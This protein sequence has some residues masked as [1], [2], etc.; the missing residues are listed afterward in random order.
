MQ[1][2]P[3]L[4]ASFQILGKRWNGL[5]IHYLSICPNNSAHFSDIKKDLTDITPRA[6]SMKLTELIELGLINKKVIE[7]S[8]VTIFYELTDMGI[9]LAEALKPV[10]AWAKNNIQLGQMNNTKSEGN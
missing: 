7:G 1:I 4:E 10:Q 3:Y 9:Q 5:I 2:C 6:L 8:S